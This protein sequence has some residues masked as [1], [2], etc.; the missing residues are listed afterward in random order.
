MLPAGAVVGNPVSDGERPYAVRVEI[1]GTDRACSGAL[2]E[3]MW[4][5]TAA[6]CF[7]DDPAQYPS[8]TPG[9]P[10][11]ATRVVVGRTDLTAGGGA[12]RSIVELVPR[13][14]RDLVLAKLSSVVQGVPTVALSAEAPV[15]GEQLA[16]AGYGRTADE[17]APIRLHGG[18]FG[19]TGTT[20]SDLNVEGQ[21]GATIC[22]GDSGGPVV[23]AG[24]GG[25]LLLGVSSRSAQ[26][27]CFGSET[28]SRAAVATRVDDI[29]TWIGT[30]VARWSLKSLANG[31]YVS[32]AINVTGEDAAMLRAS[33]DSKHTWEQFTLH[34][35]DAG[36]SVSFRSAANGLFVAPEIARTG[37]QEGML[38]ARSETAFGWERFLLVSQPQTGVYALKS[39]Q[40]GKFVAVENSWT[41]AYESLLR[42]RSDSVGGSW[43]RFALEHADNFEVAGVAPVRPTPL[44]AN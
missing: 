5:V 10:R 13:Q 38:R 18:T 33:S 35:R 4:I 39:V 41:G 3:R 37:N 26:G 31:K 30:Q 43:E 15:A 36:A 7:T 14:D 42:A 27:G 6:S 17:W 9:A 1:G 2:I 8:L 11:M 34:T 44:P 21:G 16:V 12:V 28:T 20:G 29:T 23:R 40:S 25:D 19:V 32:A 22:S 24:A